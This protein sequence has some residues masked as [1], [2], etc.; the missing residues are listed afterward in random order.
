[1]QSTP[2]ASSRTPTVVV[3]LAIVLALIG[4]GG[5][6]FGLADK[7]S[8]KVAS[9]ESTTTT[10]F[11][12]DTTFP[13]ETTT[14][15][16]GA[17]GGTTTTAKGSPVTTAKPGGGTTAT[18]ALDGVGDCPAP[19]ASSTDPGAAQAPAIGT[20]TFVSCTDSS[21]TTEVKVAAG[22]SGNGVTRRN[23]TESQGTGMSQTATE[24]YGPNGVLDEVWTIKSGLGDFKCDW[25]PD[26][27][28]F[29]AQL[30]VGKTWTSDSTCTVSGNTLHITGTGKISGRVNVNVA[31][32]MVNAWV[33]DAT[34]K[35]SGGGNE[36]TETLHDYW[37]AAHGVNVY[38]NVQANTAQGSISRVDH[39]KSL[40][41]K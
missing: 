13:G 26:L 7:P 9:T 17:A 12:T 14:T 25:N 22:A 4:V 1:M 39:L 29:P 23:I 32:T 40:T 3:V 24:A 30:S 31:G 6:A 5:V 10:E 28:L 15:A 35:F 37:D 20:Y 36:V 21:D 19:A 16:A 11:G 34:I 2:G 27:L 38:R 8:K 18:T 33:V 41:P